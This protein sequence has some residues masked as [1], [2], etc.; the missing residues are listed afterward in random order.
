VKVARTGFSESR[1]V[2]GLCRAERMPVVIGSQ[3]EG[4]LGALASIAFGAAFADTASRP[5]EATNFHDLAADL[6]EL[7]RV[8]DGHVAV[9]TAPGLGYVIDEDALAAAR[10]EG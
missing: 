1:D 5:V 3:Y 9:P 2:L 10:T 6:A 7:P 8:A 4:A